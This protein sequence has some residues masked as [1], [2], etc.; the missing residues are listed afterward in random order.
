MQNARADVTDA[1]YCLPRV[2]R[3]KCTSDRIQEVRL[4]QPQEVPID[5]EDQELANRDSPEFKAYMAELRMRLPGYARRAAT[6]PPGER[7]SVEWLG[8]MGKFW[9]E[10]REREGLSR[11]QVAKRMGVTANQIRFL[12]FGLA[13][14]E[15]LTID[16]LGRYAAALGRP[17]LLEEFSATFAP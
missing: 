5:I 1:S 14:S 11:S 8:R 2:W 3:I 17:S 15:E 16:F 6:V 9:W 7:D 13:G 4:M 10:A 12:E